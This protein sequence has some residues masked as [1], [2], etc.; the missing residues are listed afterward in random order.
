MVATERDS[1]LPTLDTSLPAA[2][3]NVERQLGPLEISRST[4]FMILAGLWSAT[5]LSALNT[6]LVATLL[7]SISSD[8][9]KSNQ[10]S[11]LGTSYLLAH[12][13]IT[14]LY[15]RLS[16]VMGR[17]GA[18][19][20]AVVSAALGTLACG[21]SGNMEVLIAARFLGGMGGGGI[22]TTSTIITSDMY[23]IRSRGL[24]QG[25][26]NL[27][28]GLGMGLGGPIGG[29]ISDRF[30]WRW[31][32]LIQMPLFILSLILTS[33]NLRYVT[34][35]KG[36]STKEVLKRIDYGGS[37]T[38]LVAVGSFLVFLST[39]YNEEQSWNHPLVITSLVLSGVF[40]LLFVIFE[41]LIA[42]EPVLA[43]F[44]LRQ[45]IPVLVGISNFLVAMCNFAVMYFF[46]TWFQTVALTSASTAG[47]HL[48]PNSMSMSIGSLF[49]GYLMHRTGKYKL[50][51]LT[52]GILPF[53]G[54]VLITFMREDSGPLQMWLS[55]IPLGF[56]NAVVLQ[57]MLIALLAHIPK[58]SMAVGTGFGQVF[59]GLGQVGGVAVSSA[60]FQS[61]L[62][63]ELRN[64]IHTPNAEEMINKIRH[65]ARL[66][67]SLPPDLQR[68]ARDSYAISL[69]AV[70][71]LAACSTFLAFLVRLPIPEKTL[72]DDEPVKQTNT[73]TSPIGEESAIQTSPVS[74]E[75]VDDDDDDNDIS[76]SLPRPVVRP[77][78][79]LSTFESVDG[80]L[81]LES[82][83][84]GGSARQR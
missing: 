79:R 24:T 69:R 23:S 58:S 67:G 38:L 45:K 72:D 52:F 32:F 10:A 47:L 64:R 73:I 74:G 84:V 81:D 26:S 54:I 56:G 15:G 66:V 43:P 16:N 46:P 48:L 49:A 29:L 30:G 9:N 12:C 18:N 22:F 71:T 20:L 62:D 50:L 59:R 83:T 4:R 80:G 53:I 3:T 34:P 33:Y 19:Q 1:L 57:T 82:D 70:F 14:P 6:T 8:F 25:V 51:N 41:L 35:G 75:A 60:I 13:T 68:A 37:I 44:L 28:N 27:F 63:S 21:L 77:R 61:K 39:K 42:P 40:F 31:A 55:I 7:P 76:P 5:F 36:K 17:R 11:W 2:R 65:S 78:R